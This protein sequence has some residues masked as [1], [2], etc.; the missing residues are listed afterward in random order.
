MELTALPEVSGICTPGIP[1]K[2]QNGRR[3][4]SGLLEKLLVFE[5]NSNSPGRSVG[6]VPHV[7]QILPT[8]L[9]AAAV[10]ADRSGA[11]T[12]CQISH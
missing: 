8:L 9:E 1:S 2:A 12:S 6:G 11:D 7:R 10:A 5:N 4:P 3:L